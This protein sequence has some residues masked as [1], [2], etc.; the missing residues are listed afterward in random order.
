MEQQANKK[1]KDLTF[2]T[3]DLV[4]VKIQPHHQTILVGPR[5]PKLSHRFYGP[6]SI[7]ESVGPVA[8]HLQLPN[9]CKIHNVFHISTL[10][11]FKGHDTTTCKTLSIAVIN[12]S[13]L[14]WPVAIVATREVLSGHNRKWKIL[15][16]WSEATMEEGTWEDFEALH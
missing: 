14:S 8:Y 13:L 15:V 2:K 4:M 12:H 1:R 6:L 11:L 10:K 5:L 9:S 16:Q 7:I 3:G